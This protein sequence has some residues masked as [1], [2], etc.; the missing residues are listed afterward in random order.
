MK[1][2]KVV[3]ESELTFLH[4]KETEKLIG[5]K[6][7]KESLLKLFDSNFPQSWLI[8]GP[9]GIG[10]ATLIYNFVNH[11]FS[12][13][14][15]DY[16]LIKRRIGLG[17][18][19]DLLVLEQG[20]NNENASKTITIEEIRR[21]ANF[22]NLTPSE[23][24]Y[25]AVIIDSADDMNI[26]S[27]NALLKLLEEPPHNFFFFLISHAPNKILPTIKSRCRQLKLA[28]PSKDETI[29]ILRYNIPNL[30]LE[31]ANR[32]II[33]AGGS[34]GLALNLSK[35]NSI[36]LYKKII[37]VLQALPIY[38]L[39]KVHKLGEQFSLKQGEEEWKLFEVI[40]SCM[41]S[42]IIKKAINLDIGENLVEGEEK[43]IEMFLQKSPVAKLN[44]LWEK[45]KQ[46]IFDTNF[47]NLDKKQTLIIIFEH[48]RKNI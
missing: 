9:K 28:M 43:V 26:N 12:L 14:D 16:S 29:D 19:P 8:T 22:A 15:K 37:A 44:D 17:S 5:H 27:A 11:I 48:L 47:S 20:M 38:D 23:S 6:Q 45:I 24:K 41:F 3:S 39:Q 7:A 2:N 46:L 10:K 40:I 42:R 13:P 4:P 33:I 31:L 35:L 32:L 25:R 1:K 18:F 30:D 36:D 21:I 34:P